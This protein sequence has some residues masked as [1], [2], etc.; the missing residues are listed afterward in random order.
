VAEVVHLTSVHIATDTRIFQKQLKTLKEDGYR[1]SLIAPGTEDLVLDGIPVLHI[2]VYKNRLSRFIF[3]AWHVYRRAKAL[4]AD[5][6]HFHDPE[7]ATVGLALRMSGKKVI[8]DVHEDMPRQLY[9]KEY[10]PSWIVRPLS[11]VLEKF[12]LFAARRFNGII[13]VTQ[14]IHARFPGEKAVMVQNFPILSQYLAI[15]TANYLLRPQTVIFMGVIQDIRGI[16]EVVEAMEEVAGKHPE[17]KFRLIGRIEPDSYRKQLEGMPGWMHVSAIGWLSQ[18][19]VNSY[20]EQ[21]RVGVVTYHPY[22]NH[23][24]AQPNKLFEY[25]AAGLPV[26]ASDFPLWRNIVDEYRCGLLVDPRSPGQVREAILWMLDHPDAAAE[27]GRRGR[28]AVIKHFNWDTE[29][30]YL[31]ELYARVLGDPNPGA[32]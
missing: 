30:G 31:R 23:I 11:W 5:L 8:Y 22:P 15:D 3:G 18:D 20:L 25:M 29:A 19:E 24:E 4:N 21:A 27:M 28:E 10:L 6:Y 14:A 26:I 16:T 7:L 2:P 17:A 1:V 32:E 12:E 13:T 9:D